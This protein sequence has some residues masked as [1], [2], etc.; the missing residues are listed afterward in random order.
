LQSLSRDLQIGA[1]HEEKFLEALELTGDVTWLSRENETFRPLLARLRETDREHEPVVYAVLVDAPLLAGGHYSPSM[2][3]E[4]V[5]PIP[6][7]H[8]LCKASPAANRGVQSV[9]DV[10]A[11]IARSKLWES[12]IAKANSTI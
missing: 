5:R 9:K 6:V 3:I 10:D 8:I 2:G 7:A 4:V 1:L 11:F 12:R